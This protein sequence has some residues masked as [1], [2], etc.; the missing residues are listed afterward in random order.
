MNKKTDCNT[1]RYYYGKE[2]NDIYLHCTARPQGLNNTNCSDYIFQSTMIF[3]FLGLEPAFDGD[4]GWI[5]ITEFDVI[6]PGVTFQAL[7]FLILDEYVAFDGTIF[8]KVARS[9]QNS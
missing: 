6:Y 1:C 9:E 3:H 7:G 5:S 4:K 8:V 2:D